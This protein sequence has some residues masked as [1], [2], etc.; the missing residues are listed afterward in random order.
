MNLHLPPLRPALAA[1]LLGSA[2]I[3]HGQEPKKEAVPSAITDPTDALKGI[4]RDV[5]GDLRP[6]SRNM[7]EAAGKASMQTAKNAEGKT[8]TFKFN[9]TTIEQFQRP[10]APDVT[11]YRIR[12]MPD[13]VR[14]SGVALGVYL[15]AVGDKSENEKLAKLKV[16]SK[17]TFS[18]KISNAEILG[19]QRAELHIDLMDAKIVK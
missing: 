3:L 6:G 13:T 11:L 19:R 4:S 16:G 7:V 12:S 1:L 9:I 8:G 17:V 15:L 14:E 5:M 2:M 10:E 18:G